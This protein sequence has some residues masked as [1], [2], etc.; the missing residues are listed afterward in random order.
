MALLEVVV[1]NEVDSM[2]LG[3]GQIQVS[4]TTGPDW[5]VCIS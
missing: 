4:I 2:A 5:V 1:R 3:V